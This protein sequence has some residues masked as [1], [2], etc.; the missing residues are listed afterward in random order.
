MARGNTP[1]TLVQIQRS[2]TSALDSVWVIDDTIAKLVGGA[3]PSLDH[4]GNIDRNVGHLGTIVANQEV[5]DSGEDISALHA[6]IAAGNAKL[7]E[8][9]WPAEPVNED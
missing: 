8:V 5:I 3:T 4:K 7:A 1:R 9:T 2:I 6:A